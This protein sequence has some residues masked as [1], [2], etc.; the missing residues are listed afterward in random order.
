MLIGK[1][2]YYFIKVVLFF[3]FSNKGSFSIKEI[4]DRL[5]ISVKV[6]EQVLL[7]LKNEGLL[8]S[9]RGP[10]G[11]YTLNS[12]VKELR[13]IDVFEMAGQKVEVLPVD[14]SRKDHIIDE[15]LADVDRTMREEMTVRLKRFKIKDLV[16]SMK[17]SMGEK[18]LNYMI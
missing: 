7:S 18:G 1:K 9:K 16:R 15:V 3:A 11:G 6:L 14:V 10:Q 2:G 13:L 12:E 5:D 4:S 17:E 8:A